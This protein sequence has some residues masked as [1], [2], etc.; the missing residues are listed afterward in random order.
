MRFTSPMMI[1]RLSMIRATLLVLAAVGT[2]SLATAKELDL[3]S[4]KGEEEEEESK[5]GPYVGFFGGASQRQSADMRIDYPATDTLPSRGLDYLVGDRDG[6]FLMGF[7]IGHS[8]RTRY[9]VEWGLEFEGLFSGTEINTGFDGG[10]NA[11]KPVGLSDVFTATADMN[12]AAFMLNGTVNL[13]LKALRPRIGPIIP[14]FRPYF[15]GGVGGAQVWFRNQRVTTFGDTFGVPTSTAASPFNIDEFVFAYQI[16]G[17]L[18][19]QLKE[20]LS[21]YAEYRWLTLEKVDVLDNLDFEYVLG[22]LRWRY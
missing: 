10:R 2:A 11:G 18:E 9:F 20:K 1:L 4:I 21:L 19:F 8:W 6:N 3:R 22:G 5:Y 17:G 14:K 12:F 13:D 16:F 15:G 7:E